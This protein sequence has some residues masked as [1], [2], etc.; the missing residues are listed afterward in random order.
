MTHLRV[1]VHTPV[2]DSTVTINTT[3]IMANGYPWQP[4]AGLQSSPLPLFGL[5]VRHTADTIELETYRGAV[6]EIKRLR[7]LLNL[8]IEAPPWDRDDYTGLYRRMGSRWEYERLCRWR[9]HRREAGHPDAGAGAI[10][11]AV[12]SA[13]RPRRLLSPS[14]CDVDPEACC[15]PWLGPDRAACVFD[16]E[17]FCDCGA[18][19][20]VL[21]RRLTDPAL[22]PV[23]PAL[24]PDLPCNCT[25]HGACTLGTCRCVDGWEGPECARAVCSG[26]TPGSLCVAPGI[27]KCAPGR[28]GEMCADVQCPVGCTD[29]PCALPSSPAT[30]VPEEDWVL[31]GALMGVGAGLMC[32][33]AVGFVLLCRLRARSQEKSYSP[34]SSPLS[35][36]PRVV[37]QTVP[38]LVCCAIVLLGV[39]VGFRRG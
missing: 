9:G 37:P 35:S 22:P 13:E 30:R 33:V 11:P 28:K 19:G 10:P 1:T 15:P 20:G 5:S 36:S 21:L 6:L 12:T 7:N 24:I 4:P 38:V 27:C 23:P 16:V 2:S 34:A 39:F 25:G 8:G 29:C 3:H 14:A 26:C 31:V 32:V 17:A 18:A